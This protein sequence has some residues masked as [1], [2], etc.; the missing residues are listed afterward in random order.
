MAQIGISY[1]TKHQAGYSCIS[2]P[3]EVASWEPFFDFRDTAYSELPEFENNLVIGSTGINYSNLD[4]IKGTTQLIFR[5]DYGKPG[6]QAIPHINVDI[7]L[8]KPGSRRRMRIPVSFNNDTGFP[9]II[10]MAEEIEIQVTDLDREKIL[11]HNKIKIP[12][13]LK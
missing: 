6:S 3:D 12:S 9:H 1:K 2:V 10:K 7:G 13:G 5:A 11:F 4:G 8:P